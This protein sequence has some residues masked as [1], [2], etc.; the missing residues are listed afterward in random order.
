MA[1]QSDAIKDRLE[2]LKLDDRRVMFDSKLRAFQDSKPPE[3]AGDRVSKL[4]WKTEQE[5]PLN[6]VVSLLED[7]SRRI[8]G[9]EKKDRAL[10]DEIRQR[11]RRDQRRRSYFYAGGLAASGFLVLGWFMR[12]L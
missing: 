12:W 11:G 2:A 5:N 4:T 9:L 3:L 8:D 1:L 7:L 6:Q 10:A